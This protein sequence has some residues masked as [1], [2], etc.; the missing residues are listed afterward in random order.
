MRLA[1]SRLSLNA[2]RLRSRRAASIA[3]ILL[4]LLNFPYTATAETTVTGRDNQNKG[5][6]S[7][8][9]DADTPTGQYEADKAR[10][11]QALRS[12][13]NLEDWPAV[14]AVW[15]RIAKLEREHGKT[16]LARHAYGAALRV[17]EEHDLGWLAFSVQWDLS[18]LERA[19][20]RYEQARIHLGRALDIA[21][22]GSNFGRIA[23]GPLLFDYAMLHLHSRQYD[24]AR[25]LLKQSLAYYDA[26]SE[27]V[28]RAD[29][30]K[31]LGRVEGLRNQHDAARAALTEAIEIYGEK[32]KDIPRADALTVL[33]DLQHRQGDIDGAR[34]HYSEALRIYEVRKEIS[35]ITRLREKL[36][37]LR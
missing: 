25:Q 18:K 24:R 8:I 3:H 30:L 4:F 32:G 20:K 1:R 23:R 12:A 22:P 29:V 7:R 11:E 35:S 34:T 17:A 33:G 16:A 21:K 37:A 9:V 13:Q 26:P 28:A 15:Q 6:W 10:Y 2:D 27:K 19:V 14:G 36:E 31:S 5:L